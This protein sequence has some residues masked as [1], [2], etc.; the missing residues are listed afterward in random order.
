MSS[1]HTAR[2][3]LADMACRQTQEAMAT[4]DPLVPS[5]M[6]S[7]A[8]T[9]SREGVRLVIVYLYFVCL[10]NKSETKIEQD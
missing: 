4:T 7:R 2:M 8:M 10:V 6:D 1:A 3:S 5:I 9:T